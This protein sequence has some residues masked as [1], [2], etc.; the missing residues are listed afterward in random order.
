MSS[1]S[2][3]ARSSSLR[4]AVAR[5]AIAL[6]LTSYRFTASAK[7]P[8]SARRPKIDAKNFRI[9]VTFA[10]ASNSASRFSKSKRD[11]IASLPSTNKCRTSSG[12]CSTIFLIRSNE[13][14]NRAGSFHNDKH[15]CGTLNP[16]RTDVKYGSSCLLASI[17]TFILVIESI[18]P[19]NNLCE[20]RGRV[21]VKKSPPR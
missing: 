21:I 12:S 3:G 13:T 5:A 15:I 7:R 11:I 14:S 2:S 4:Q 19:S 6:L 9:S 10:E 8:L 18:K 17:S 1:S 20:T 16:T